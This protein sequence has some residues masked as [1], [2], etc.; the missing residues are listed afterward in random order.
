MRRSANRPS[1]TGRDEAAARRRF[2]VIAAGLIGACFATG[3]RADVEII[4]LRDF[5]E[6][7]LSFTPLATS[8]AGQRVAVTGYMAPPL[9]AEAEFFVLTKRPMADCPFCNDASDWPD[10]I[11]AVFTKRTVR[12]EPFN[13]GIVVRGR[14][15]LGDA[16]DPI[17]GFFSRLR[18]VDAVVERT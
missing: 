10:D 2:L 13:A 6:K 9:K 3:G 12:V 8:L 15:E 17:T 14:L 4:K 18:L 7:D 5:Y 11:V 1:S 16:R